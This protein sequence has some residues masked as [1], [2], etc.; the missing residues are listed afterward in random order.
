MS[1]AASTSMTTSP[2]ARGYRDRATAAAIAPRT[3]EIPTP[4]LAGL[5]LDEPGHRQAERT[6]DAALA[7]AV[8]LFAAGGLWLAVP[9]MTAPFLFTW[10]LFVVLY[11]A[12]RVGWDLIHRL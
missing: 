11:V 7:L 6:A 9:R 4:D 12:G 2:H 3:W 10:T 1:I 5:H 8:L